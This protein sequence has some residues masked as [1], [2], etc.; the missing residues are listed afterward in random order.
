VGI[1]QELIDEVR[2]YLKAHRRP[3]VSLAK[4]VGIT[5]KHLNQILMGKS[6]PRPELWDALLHNAR[7]W[8]KTPQE[9]PLIKRR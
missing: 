7:H 8:P 6:W 5:N 2:G 9:Y 3:Q 1:Q 4:A